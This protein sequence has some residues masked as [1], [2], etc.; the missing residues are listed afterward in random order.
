MRPLKAALFLVA[1]GSAS[2]M[3]APA[4]ADEASVSAVQ[5]TLV[6]DI[7]VAIN[8]LPPGSSAGAIEAAIN[9]TIAKTGFSAS[10]VSAALKVVQTAEASGS[11]ASVAVASLES[12]VSGSSIPQGGGVGG[13]SP[14]G[15]LVSGSSGGSGY[16][17]P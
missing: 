1:W 5:A 11:N 13:G 17:G 12:A 10:V 14:I 9:A 4:M 8:T 2:L 15:G 16:V 3:A 6:S 7:E